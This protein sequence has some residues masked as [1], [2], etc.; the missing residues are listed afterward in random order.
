VQPSPSCSDFSRAHDEPMIGTASRVR[1]WLLIEQGGEWG[2]DAVMESELDPVI[3]LELKGRVGSRVRILLIQRAGS[4]G[5]SRRACFAAH[6]S[7]TERWVQRW[8]IED[9]GELLELDVDALARG[10]RPSTGTTWEGPLYLVCTNGGRDQCCRIRGRPAAERLL[11]L[12]PDEAWGSSHVGGDRFAPN[13]VCLPHGLYFGRADPEG[14]EG[15]VA[16]YEG[17]A[18]DLPHFRG[19][20]SYEPV[21]QAGEVLVRAR[22]GIDGVD[23]LV[24]ATRRDHGGGRSTLAFTDRAG[25]SHDIVLQVRRGARRPLTCASG[26]PGAPLEF[27]E[28]AS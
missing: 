18:I 9:P 11:G 17:G 14:I 12:R 8:D 10:A 20:S 2:Y 27:F 5:R 15:I 24:L 7:P 13:I 28:L 1:N 26:F 23:D 21:V 25:G 19:R 4:A 6:T 16:R 3:G 22:T